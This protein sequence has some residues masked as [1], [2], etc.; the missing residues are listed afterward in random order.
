MYLSFGFWLHRSFQQWSEDIL[1]IRLKEVY[2]FGAILSK[3]VLAA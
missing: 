3:E 1:S 2:H